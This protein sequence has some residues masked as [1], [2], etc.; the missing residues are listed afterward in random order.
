MP[1]LE[2]SVEELKGWFKNNVRH[3][4]FEDSINKAKALRV[5]SRG[6]FPETLI[7]ERRPNEPDEVKEYRKKIFVPKTKPTFGKVVSSLSKIRRSADWSI[8][9]QKDDKFTLVR[10]GEKMEQYCE[11]K[12]P[13]F[14]SITNWT[15]SVLL[16]QYLEDP[17]AV[18]FTFPLSLD[19]QENDYLKPFP[20][21][22]E[23]ENVIWFEPEDFAVLI[24]PLG[25]TYMAKGKPV[26]GQSFYVVNTERILKFDQVNGRGDMEIVLDDLHGLGYCPV[27]KIKGI[28]A[29]TAGNNYLYE[30]RVAAMLPELDEALREYSDLQASKVIHIYP[31]RWEF[32]NREC[33]ECKGVGKVTTFDKD[34]E[35]CI[36]KCTKCAGEGYVVAGPYSKIM[37]KPL[38]NATDGQG[39][40]PTPPAGFIEKDVEIVRIQDEGVEKHLTSALAAI[41]FE[42]LAAAPLNQSGVAKETDKDELNNTV[43]AIAED[44]IRVLDSVYKTI[45]ITRYKVQYSIEDIV[46]DMV[47]DISVP[48]KYDLLSSAHLEE[49]LTT[50]KTNK[51]NPVII[52]ALESEYAGKKFNTDPEIRDRLMLI[53]ELD[54]LPNVGE[55]DKF[56]RLSN[57]GI[58]L[59]TYV[60]SSNIQEFVQRAIDEDPQFATK[61][62]KDKKAKMAEY[63]QA[64]IDAEN[65]A[66]LMAADVN[67]ESGLDANGNPL[68]APP[69]NPVVKIPAAA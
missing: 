55:D 1:K 54:P 23:S 44:I 65:E 60:I 30:S 51:T 62:L 12:F 35:P 45:A 68:P 36:E 28:V 7:T 69:V 18:V 24:N 26:N 3:H 19:V 63:A 40:I 52:N 59:I 13:Y 39:T 64:Q 61:K 20:V 25:A 34:D 48:E 50:A 4:F 41:N 14:T 29:G 46:K 15:F 38:N 11:E 53:L 27:E 67:A 10:D 33:G 56:T 66:K 43:H 31:E 37:I 32:T 57:K 47:P 6:E 2:F 9:Y 49:E 22:F 21:I 58:S 17:N 8:R 42:F 5:H 16:R